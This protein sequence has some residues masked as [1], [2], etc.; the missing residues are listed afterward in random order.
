MLAQGSTPP[1]PP[2]FSEYLLTDGEDAQ[3]EHI[4]VVRR[5]DEHFGVSALR[6]RQ[7]VAAG[8]HKTTRGPMLASPIPRSNADLAQP[9]ASITT[10]AE[11]GEG[12]TSTL[13]LQL[14]GTNA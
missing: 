10:L 1:S 9:T 11:S 14:S 8:L 3:E 2:T 6:Y 4:H 13:I 12:S 7:T 5:A